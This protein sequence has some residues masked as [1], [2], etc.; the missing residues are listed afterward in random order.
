MSVAVVDGGGGGPTAVA[1]RLSGLGYAVTLV[2]LEAARHRRA[3][4]PANV[5]VAYARPLGVAVSPGALTDSYR[6]FEFLRDRADDAIVF[7]DTGGHGLCSAQARR[8]GRAFA[9]TSIVTLCSEPRL[10][11]AERE[12]GS[13]LSISDVRQIVTERLQIELSDS[14]V[15]DDEQLDWM[16]SRGWGIPPAVYGDD[17]VGWHAAVETRSPAS[18]KPDLRPS[19]TAVIATYERPH[20]LPYCV[21]AFARQRYPRLEI[22]VV[23]DGSSSPDARQILVDLE[24]RPWPYPLRVLREPHLGVDAARNAGWAAATG[25]LVVFFDDDDVPRDDMIEALVAA[26][27]ASGA[28]VVAA[29]QRTFDGTG[30]PVPGP[31][32]VVG[33][34]LGR[35]Y[36][37][38]L[39]K[40]QYGSTVCLWPRALLDRVG[41]FR[42]AATTQEDGELLAR[43]TLAGASIIGVP[44]ALYWCRNSPNSR[45]AR[46]EQM[47]Y[48]WPAVVAQ[49]HANRLPAEYGL[50]PLLVGGAYAEVERIN[51]HRRGAVKG[52]SPVGALYRRARNLVVKAGIGGVIRSTA[53]TFRRFR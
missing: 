34:F 33:V 6:F 7:V 17:D 42:H 50:L 12:S 29:G 38:G 39:L 8:T 15:A 14:L 31:E 16:R 18:R 46:G 44:E 5:D 47:R 27:T 51:G 53:H 52:M 19:V 30:D 24:S 41:G 20:V 13:F 23:D 28:D 35:P 21:E 48:A 3:A 26:R 1:E 22:V 32:D 40:N 4:L 49:L 9:N 37:L 45:Y 43:A 10:R 36:E 11:R 2:R 25:E